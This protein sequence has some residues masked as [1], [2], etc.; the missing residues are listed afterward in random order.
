[1]LLDHDCLNKVDGDVLI[2]IPIPYSHSKE[3]RPYNSL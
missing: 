3:K 2:F 1:M